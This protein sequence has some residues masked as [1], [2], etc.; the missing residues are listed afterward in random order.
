MDTK[1]PPSFAAGSA[2]YKDEYIR[3]ST[4]TGNVQSTRT[5]PR[6]KESPRQ[7]PPQIHIEGDAFEAPVPTESTQPDLTE[8]MDRESQEY[9]ISLFDCI[10]DSF[11]VS[12]AEFL[13]CAKQYSHVIEAAK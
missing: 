7:S 9:P 2:A 10:W 8:Q 1:S 12:E 13:G 5:H 11:R 4:A 6:M 3:T